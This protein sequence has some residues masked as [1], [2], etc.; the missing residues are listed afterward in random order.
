MV[1]FIVYL[2][3]YDIIINNQVLGCRGGISLKDTYRNR[4]RDEATEKIEYYII[5]NKLAPHTKILSERDMC[6]MWNF[7]R[8]TLRSA[9]QRLIVEGKLYQKKGSGTYVA[10]PKLTRDLQD[11]VALCE[12]ARQSGR[13]ITNKILSFDIMESNRQLT[14]KLHLPLGQR[15]HALTRLRY[16]DGEPVAIENSFMDYER[17]SNLTSHDFEKESLYE[18]IEKV[19]NVQI[20]RGEERV[21][22]AYA[23]NYEAEL[24]EIEPGKAVFY[25][26]GIT[27]DGEGEPVEYFKTIVRSDKIRFASILKR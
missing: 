4:S 11:L 16:L 23:T 12:V 15:V 25:L 26:S 27:Y 20:M 18:V 13:S 14:Q 10:Q 7:N 17:F 3:W 21:G 19:Y 6:A 22:I 24:L 2:P 8:T 1:V 5:K 9:I